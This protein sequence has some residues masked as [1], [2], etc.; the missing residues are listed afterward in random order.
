M[1]GNR[2]IAGARLEPDATAWRR[3][4]TWGATTTPEGQDIRWT[5][6]SRNAV[7]GS[8]CGGADCQGP[9]TVEAASADDESVVWG[10]ADAESVVWGTSADDESVVWG[11]SCGDPACE[12]V[13][14]GRP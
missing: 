1:W 6:T 11:T 8:A 4:V 12:P 3:G 13:V 2:V 7:W 10:T 5:G 9:W 14:W